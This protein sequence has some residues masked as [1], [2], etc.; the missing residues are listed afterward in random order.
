VE[1]DKLAANAV[2]AAKI[3]AGTITANELAATLVFTN[4][5]ELS[6]TGKIRKAKTSASNT[7]KGIWIGDDGAS[8]DDV[9]IGD[10]ST[11]FWFDYS[12]GTIKFRGI[13]DF[14]AQTFTPTWTGFSSSPSG[15]ISYI[16]F[17]SFVLMFRASALTGTSNA[18]T[19]TITNVPSAIRPSGQRELTCPITN[20]SNLVLGGTRVQENDGELK[21]EVATASGSEML[22]APAGFSSSGNK[23]LPAGWMIIYPK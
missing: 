10:A 9:H 3:T 6:S 19:M 1:T 13:L 16:D 8:G 23:G 11:Y 22:F 14:A 12:A 4:D 17:G 18:T 15:D 21:F 20:A 7:T 2:T 5:L